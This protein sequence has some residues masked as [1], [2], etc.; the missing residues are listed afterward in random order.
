M[1]LREIFLVIGHQNCRKS[2][3]VRALT[4]AAQRGIYSIA[5]NVGVFEFFV[6]IQSLQEI[7]TLP[8]LFIQEMETHPE[9]PVKILTS[10][11]IDENV[12]SG[13]PAGEEYLRLFIAHGWRVQGIIVLGA[14]GLQNHL[15]LGY[16]QPIFIPNPTRMANNQIAAQA[17]NAWNW[18]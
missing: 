2:S 14:T 15:P 7:P 3:T 11:W 8:S 5:T 1:T 13:C 18:V 4:G 6:Q 12:R 9:N 10:L 17:K 16:P